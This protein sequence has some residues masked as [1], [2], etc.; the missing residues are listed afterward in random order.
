MEV[1]ILDKPACSKFICEEMQRF[2]RG[3]LFKEKSLRK[4]DYGQHT[5][6]DPN[7]STF[8]LGTWFRGCHLKM[9]Y[10]QRNHLC[11]FGRGHYGE[12]SC[13]LI[14]FLD[15]WFRRGMLY[16]GKVYGWHTKNHWLEHVICDVV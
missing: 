4:A 13:K 11:N 2:K 10:I 9:F 16:K 7:S 5:K 1:I 12:Y 14:L 3:M 8:N 6:T 15:Q